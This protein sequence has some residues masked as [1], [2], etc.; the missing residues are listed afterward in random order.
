LICFRQSHQFRAS[1][2]HVSAQA[3]KTRPSCAL[4]TNGTSGTFVPFVP[5]A[6]GTG[7]DIHLQDVPSCPGCPLARPSFLCPGEPKPFHAV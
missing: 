1:K 4:G 2:L 6:R 5:A 3:T 7:R